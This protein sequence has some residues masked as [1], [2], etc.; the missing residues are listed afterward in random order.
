[1]HGT[2][3]KPPDRIA[4]H[5][6]V[7]LHGYFRS[8]HGLALITPMASVNAAAA[9]ADET[10]ISAWHPPIAADYGGSFFKNASYFGGC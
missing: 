3:T 1:M 5:A 2:C 4:G 6:K 7:M 8:H 10:P 9:I